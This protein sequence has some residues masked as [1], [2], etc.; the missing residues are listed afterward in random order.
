[1]TMTDQELQRHNT[2]CD[3]LIAEGIVGRQDEDAI[4]RTCALADLSV[5]LGRKDGISVVLG[6]YEIL[7][8]KGISGEK[9]IFLDYSRANAIAGER[10]AT[11]WKWE[12]P[13]LV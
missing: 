12:Q 11:D 1:M 4:A 6:W 10:Y 7:E 8:R 3:L 5:K 9:A 13:T 2:Q